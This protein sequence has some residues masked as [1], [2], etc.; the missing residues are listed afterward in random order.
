ME[1]VYD[2]IKK[3]IA[4]QFGNA[5]HVTEIQNRQIYLN[6]EL[7]SQSGI[8]RKDIL[9]AIRHEILANPGIAD[10]FDSD[11]LSEARINAYQ[12]EL[13]SNDLHAKRS[14]D[15]QI[16]M[17]PGWINKADYGTSH[18]SAYNYDT[19]VPLLLYGWGIQSGETTRRTY[20]SDIA[21]TISSLLNI[22]APSGSIGNVV[23]E[24]LK[25]GKSK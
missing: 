1:A 19:Q 10:V 11:A 17:A 12:R 7:L 18:G 2:Q 21:P 3:R 6:H 9:T 16:V 24:A 22:L 20:I 13:F 4:K 14:G 23:T 15:L 25:S 8:S 5:A